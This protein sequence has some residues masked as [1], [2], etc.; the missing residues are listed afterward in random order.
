M[1]MELGMSIAV[2]DGGTVMDC[3]YKMD[4]QGRSGIT[5]YYIINCN[6]II[7]KENIQ[8]LDIH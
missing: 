1:Q 3:G 2:V 5:I 4:E 8:H 7:K 6:F